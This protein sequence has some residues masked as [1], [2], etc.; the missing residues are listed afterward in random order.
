MGFFSKSGHR[1]PLVPR[2]G[3]GCAVADPLRFIDCYAAVAELGSQP[4]KAD[5]YWIAIGEMRSLDCSALRLPN[6]C[7]LAFTAQIVHAGADRFEIVRSSRVSHLAPPLSGSSSV[8]VPCPLSDRALVSLK[9]QVVRYTQR[10]LLCGSDAFLT[11]LKGLPANPR[12]PREPPA[13]RRRS[14]RQHGFFL[15]RPTRPAAPGLAASDA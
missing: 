3:A 11:Y 2:V 10:S 4:T 5:D 12:G 9:S 7:Q 13:P 6:G 8:P 14:R 15:S 1:H